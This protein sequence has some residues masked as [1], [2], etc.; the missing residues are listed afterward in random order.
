MIGVSAQTYDLDGCRLFM[1]ADLETEAAN[2]TLSRRATR[3]ATLD[4]GVVISDSGAAH[5]DRDITVVEP[6]AS[7]EVVAWAAYIVENYELVTVTMRDGAFSG[8]P[9]TFG[10]N[11]GSLELKI[12]VK[13]KLSD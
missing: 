1:Q 13:E 2:R 12:L 8:C 3:T 7:E 9:E 10:I 5:G 4:G 11:A 6:M